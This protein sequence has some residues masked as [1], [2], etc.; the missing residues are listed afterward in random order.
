M[1]TVTRVIGALLV[2]T[3]VVAY[4]AT[5]RESLTALAPSVVGLLLLALGLLA[6][7][8]ERTRNMIHAAL[9]VSLLGL[10]ASGMPLRDLP[11][12]LD[13]DADRPGAVVASA[14]MAV[15]CLV[16]LALGVR[17]FMAA[18]RRRTTPNK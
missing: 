17:S 3:G 4:L 9:A 12:L 6:G 11:A 15:L 10:L 8:P 14:A 13:G 5:A 1:I 16:H 18:R 2:L 7:K